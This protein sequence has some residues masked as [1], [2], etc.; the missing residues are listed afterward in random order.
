MRLAL[1]LILVAT[2]SARA[3]DAASVGAAV[4]AGG[5]GAATYGAVE[6]RFDAEWHGARVGLGARGVWL[7]GVFRRGDWS[8]LADAVTLVR[9]LEAHTGELAIAAGGLTPGQL[10]HVVD[11]YRASLDDRQRTGVRGRAMT[12]TVT[13]GLELDDVLDPALVA[14]A[15]AWQAAPPWGIHAAAAVDP[16]APTGIESAIELGVTR[17]WEAKAARAEIGGAVVGE[18]GRGASIVTFATAALDRAGARWSATTEARAGGGTVGAAF[19]PLYRV[20]RADLYDRAHA[21]VGA[22]IGLGVASPAGWLSAGVRARPGMGTLGT[23]SAGAPM[24]RWIQAA[25]WLAATKHDAA[26]AA[27]LRVAWARPL[28]SSVQV[29]RMYT[30]EVMRPSPMWSVTAWF[31]AATP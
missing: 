23:L 30:T 9:Y 27:E 21:G 12:R 24:G 22:A 20:E 7:D 26:G 13:L 18:P 28:F 6:L 19:G 14:G 11:G 2:A 29:A 15:V 8:R 17:R 25:A 4:G 1:A 31:G 16:A 5:Q 3:D 10:A